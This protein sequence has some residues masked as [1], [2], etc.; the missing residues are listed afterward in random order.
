MLNRSDHILITSDFP[1]GGEGEGEKGGTHGI[2]HHSRSQ[3]TMGTFLKDS[4]T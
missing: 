4:F 1:R 2:T 3:E